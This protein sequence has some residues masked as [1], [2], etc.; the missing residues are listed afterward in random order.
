VT[1]ATNNNVVR[2]YPEP[3][4]NVLVNSIRSLLLILFIPACDILRVVGLE[5][6]VMILWFKGPLPNDNILSSLLSSDISFVDDNVPPCT[7]L[8]FNFAAHL[9]HVSMFT[10]LW[11]VNLHLPHLTNG[12]DNIY[13]LKTVGT[14][15]I[16]EQCSREQ[17]I[18][19]S[20]TV[21]ML[22]N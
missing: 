7:R 9:G 22:N 15:I 6:M 11:K 5:V 2:A 21:L 3:K 13:Y 19:S 4:A 12:V 16:K 8:G 18:T 14:I 1:L 17:E 20:K 10:L